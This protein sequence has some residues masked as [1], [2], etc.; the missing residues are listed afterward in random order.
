MATKL[1]VNLRDRDEVN[2]F[3]D[4]SEYKQMLIQVR[5]AIPELSNRTLADTLFAIGKLHK[6][7]AEDDFPADSVLKPFLPHMI[8]D[9]LKELTQRAA[10]LN[11][12]EI[13]YIGKA[14]VN[15]RRL[16]Q[17]NSKHVAFESE[18]RSKLL[19]HLNTAHSV[20]AS[21]DPYA[22]SKLLRYLFAFNDSSEHAVELY[23]SLNLLL[24]TTIEDRQRAL[25]N[26]KVDDPLIDLEM[27]DLVDIVRVYGVFASQ[28]A[29][30]DTVPP[31]FTDEIL[32]NDE[33]ETFEN[34]PR[35]GDLTA[36]SLHLLK[37]L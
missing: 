33:L 1:K 30:R 5:K 20:V 35:N 28:N 12:M 29:A 17:A 21:F 25:I 36:M 16:V 7:Q 24:T 34:R 8:G 26:A 2:K 13:A 22:S 14:L 3:I 10:S 31:L 32:H 19:A 9:F 4:R 23:K 6:G 11:S 15:L 27:H 37:A 18:F